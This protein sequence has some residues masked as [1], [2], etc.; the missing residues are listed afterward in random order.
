MDETTMPAVEATENHDERDQ[1]EFAFHLLPTVADGEVSEVLTH[2]K[3]IITS[4]GGEVIDEEIPQRFTLAYE[5]R[6]AIEGR[7]LRYTNSWFGWIRFSLMRKDLES[8]T[9]EIVH[10]QEVLRHLIIRLTKEEA[11]HPYHIFANKQ[12][13]ATVVG[14]EADSEEAVGEVSLDDLNKSI[15]EITS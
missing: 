5:M 6:K 9:T 8:V 7:S 3:T 12:E 1:Y 11:E 15:E 14:S 2:L 4:H 10:R 13:S